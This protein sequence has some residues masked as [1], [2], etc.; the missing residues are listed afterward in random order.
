MLFEK[1]LA[2]HGENLIITKRNSSDKILDC[3]YPTTEN[4]YTLLH[5]FDTQ[6]LI[7]SPNLLNSKLL[8]LQQELSNQYKELFLRG[9]LLVFSGIE[10]EHQYWLDVD[11][12]LKYT[13]NES[14]FG[15]T[16]ETRNQ[17]Y[18]NP[19]IDELKKEGMELA[20]K[21]NALSKQQKRRFF[22][23]LGV[24]NYTINRCDIDINCSFL[25]GKSCIVK[26]SSYQNFPKN[27]CVELNKTIKRVELECLYNEL[28][29][30]PPKLSDEE[31][32]NWINKT[33]AKVNKTEI[34]YK[35]SNF[36]SSSSKF[37]YTKN[38]KPQIV[39]NAKISFK[40]EH[41]HLTCDISYTDMF[42]KIDNCTYSYNL[43]YFSLLDVYEFILKEFEQT[44]KE[45]KVCQYCGGKFKGLIKKVCSK[46]G[47]EKSY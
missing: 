9:D 41:L 10:K 21:I 33:L 19:V 28:S 24:D 6:L 7:Y 22:L 3:P 46:C 45:N 47:K 25:L 4:S 30:A 12:E 18:H 2:V 38:G 36:D 32:I 8:N 13:Y 44:N 35:L 5:P 15:E 20:K 27:I 31:M 23:H 26:E 29:I 14:F 11:S 43:E 42:G 16:Y 1:F 39:N 34:V 17:K 40:Y 37:S